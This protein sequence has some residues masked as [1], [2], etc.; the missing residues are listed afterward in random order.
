MV[1]LHLLAGAAVWTFAGIGVRVRHQSVIDQ[2]SAR[3]LV[4][5]E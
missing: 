3:H 2:S 5:I 4:F 1:D